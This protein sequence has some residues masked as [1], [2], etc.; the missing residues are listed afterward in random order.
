MVM[1]K[2]GGPPKR[3][4]AVERMSDLDRAKRMFEM[5]LMGVT[6]MAIGHAFDLSS[7][8]VHQ[9]LE[10]YRRDE[11]VPYVEPYRDMQRERAEYLWNKLLESGKLEKGDPAAFNA[12]VNILKRMAANDGSDAPTQIELTGKVDPKEIELHRMII[13]AK[14]EAKRQIRAIQGSV[15]PEEDAEDDGLEESDD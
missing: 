9:I 4:A 1:G 11:L 7:G 3:K 15:E 8:Q 2:R 13:E 14:R 12:G 5:R 6:L 10:K